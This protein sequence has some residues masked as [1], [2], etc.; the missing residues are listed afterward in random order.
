M[1]VINEFSLTDRNSYDQN[2]LC[3]KRFSAAKNCFFALELIFCNR[4]LISVDQKE[5]PPPKIYLLL[6]RGISAAQ[7]QI[8]AIKMNYWCHN[9]IFD[10]QNEFLASEVRFVAI[11]RLFS[12]RSDFCCIRNLFSRS[13]KLASTVEFAIKATFWHQTSIF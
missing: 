12:D 5:S 2:N 7:K 11:K 6:S 9:Q 3:S 10:D 1:L 4:N 13:A 8:F